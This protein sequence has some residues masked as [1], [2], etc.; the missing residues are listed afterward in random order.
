MSLLDVNLK[1]EY[2]S[3]R[4]D[5][6]NKFYIPLLKESILYKRSVGF[7]SSSSLLEISYGITKLINNKG[8]I[9]LIVSPNLSEEDIDAINKG[10]E[11]R[12][13]VIER[14]LLQYITEP[15]NYFEEE[16]LNLLA[17]L[18]AEEKLDIKI[19]FSLKNQRLGLYHEKLG[20]MYDDENNVIAFSGSMNETENAFINNYEIVDVFTSWEDK[21]RV[22]IKERAFDKLWS[23]KR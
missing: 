10:Y 12:E 19:A 6:V 17:T 9:Q 18:I 16:R 20:L 23:D 21:D 8:K 5:I 14:A 3:P 15:H 22:E 11:V 13:D 1:K 2:R 4:D 7:F